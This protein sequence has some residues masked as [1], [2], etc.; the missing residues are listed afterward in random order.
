MTSEA[1]GAVAGEPVPARR[2][3]DASQHRAATSGGH[4]QLVL[5]GPGSGK[6]TTLAGM[7][8]VVNE[9]RSVHVLTLEDPIEI[10]HRS[11]IATVTQRELGSDSGS[12]ACGKKAS[13]S[14]TTS[15]RH[16]R[17]HSSGSARARKGRGPP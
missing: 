10:L 16:A 3:L 14:S 5:A 7:I 1:H 9:R 2:R 6:T 13:M 4:I 11:K 15:S 8:D 17:T 12:P